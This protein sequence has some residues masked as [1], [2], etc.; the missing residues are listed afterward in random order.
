[1]QASSQITRGGA[2]KPR[3]K[4]NTMCKCVMHTSAT[5]FSFFCRHTLTCHQHYLQLRKDLLEE[6]LHC[7]E[8]TA[9]LLASLALQ[10]EYGDHQAEVQ[11]SF[12]PW[13]ASGC[14]AFQFLCLLCSLRCLRCFRGSADLWFCVARAQICFPGELV[15]SHK[16]KIKH[17]EKE[18][19]L[20]SPS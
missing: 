19:F 16:L 6:R 20:P 12:H 3:G 2:S 15:F 5:C 14:Y 4:G 18:R 8:E 13:A 7:D 9:L 1:M 17:W 10:A 11:L